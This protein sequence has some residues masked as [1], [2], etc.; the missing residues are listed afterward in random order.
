MS[1]RATCAGRAVCEELARS[2][3]SSAGEVDGSADREEDNEDKE[4]RRDCQRC[5]EWPVV[6]DPELVRD[7]V[8]DH[9]PVRPT[10]QLRCDVVACGKHKRECKGNLD[11]GPGEREEDRAE[12]R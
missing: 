10:N 11:P 3:S 6:R 9:D 8:S 2:S 7:D 5:A 4:Q 12:D 1:L